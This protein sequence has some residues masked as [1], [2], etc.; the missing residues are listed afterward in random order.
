M[1]FTRIGSLR[2]LD[3]IFGGFVLSPS[4]SLSLSLATN[5]RPPKDDRR[6]IRRGDD[7][8]R[9]RRR[10]RRRR[11]LTIPEDSRNIRDGRGGRG[12]DLRSSTISSTR[13]SC[14]SRGPR[15]RSTTSDIAFPRT[16]RPMISRCMANPQIAAPDNSSRNSA[17]PRSR[18]RSRSRE[19]IRRFARRVSRVSD[20]E[21]G[22]STA[23]DAM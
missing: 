22:R 16:D 7:S 18:A 12:V 17:R 19:A 10:R 13:R 6:L 11:L 3:R 23:E 14:P 15:R 21:Y 9:L 5:E 1:I 8:R 20:T 4:L 2:R